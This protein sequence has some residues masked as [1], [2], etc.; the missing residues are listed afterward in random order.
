[1]SVEVGFFG[2]APLLVGVADLDLGKS[3]L[4]VQLL[5]SLDCA[6]LV[7]FGLFGSVFR[8]YSVQEVFN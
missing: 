2:S 5:I 4:I 1:V 3:L 6:F 7:N 8:R